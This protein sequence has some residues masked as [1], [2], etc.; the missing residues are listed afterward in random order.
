MAYNP[1]IGSIYHLYTTYILPSFGGY[2]IPTTLYRN[3]KNPLTFLSF[4]T[5]FTTQSTHR[6]PVSNLLA[7]MTSLDTSLLPYL[8]A[9]AASCPRPWRRRNAHFVCSIPEADIFW[10]MAFK[11][12]DPLELEKKVVVSKI[13]WVFSTIY[14]KQILHFQSFFVQGVRPP[15]PSKE[16]SPSQICHQMEEIRRSP[17]DK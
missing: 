7:W 8:L 10:G 13:C 15:P 11:T 17:V 3:L 16:C 12:R 2:I 1:P 9:M 4:L 14:G 6:G 5:C